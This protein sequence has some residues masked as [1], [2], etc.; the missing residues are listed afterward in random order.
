MMANMVVI[1]AAYQAGALPMSAAAIERA[2]ALNGVKVE[3]NQHA[4]RAG[5]LA[6]AEPGWLESLQLKRA[7]AVTVAPEPSAAAQ[8]LIDSVKAQGEL[9]RLLEVRVPEL[10]AY[11]N[12]SYARR[13]LEDVKRVFAAELALCPDSTDLSEA[14][15]RYLFKLMAYKDEYEVARLSLKREVRT[16]MEEQFGARAKMHYHLQPPLLKTLGLKRKIK[17][18]R[19]FDVV[20]RALRQLRF[21]RGTPFDFFGY[22]RVRR[23]ERDLIVQ[24]RRLIFD[25][26]TTL[27]EENYAQVTKLAALPDMIRGYDEVKLGNVKRFWEAV[28]ALGFDAPGD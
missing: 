14:F 4:F 25:A 8:K 5:R 11:Q 17:V 18:G 7:G 12:E 16:A 3:D 22:D 19:S 27:D 9:K 21:L 6:V 24:Y 10:I 28:R 26:L 1:G 23:T 20:Y 15:A 13:Y 2:I